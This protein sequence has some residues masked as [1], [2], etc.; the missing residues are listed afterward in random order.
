MII[1]MYIINI[2]FTLG[3]GESVL[4]GCVVL[5]GVLKCNLL[6]FFFGVD[7]GVL[8]SLFAFGVHPDFDGVNWA[9][10][11]F[12]VDKTELSGIFDEL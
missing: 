12:L 2:T 5:C 8:I 10:C 9:L 4:V 3:P 7:E 6:L 11:R 1:H